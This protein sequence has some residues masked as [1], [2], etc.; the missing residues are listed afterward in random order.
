MA[1]KEKLT[2]AQY[3]ALPETKPYLEY[4]CEEVVRKAMPNTDHFQ[5]VQ[6]VALRVGRHDEQAAGGHCGPEPRIRF[7][8][9][10]GLEYRIPDFAYWAPGRPFSDG[11]DMLPAT[12]AVE[13]RS[14]DETMAEQREKCR[15]YR[16]YGVQVCWLFDPPTRTVEVFEGGVDGE[17]RAVL[18]SAFV[19]GL[20]I[21]AA[22]LFPA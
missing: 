2:V 4:V 14:P 9:E 16:R 3:L 13:V 20:R 22:T 15:Y 18:E 11:D 7:A 5:I 6:K 1:V 10:R 19:P 12:L 8:T 21:V 17:V